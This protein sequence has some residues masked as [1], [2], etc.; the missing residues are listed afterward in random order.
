MDVNTT[1]NVALRAAW[2]C[3]G[4]P[5]LAALYL[6]KRLEQLDIVAVIPAAVQEESEI[7]NPQKVADRALRMCLVQALKLDLC[8]HEAVPVSQGP[9]LAAWALCKASSQLASGLFVAG[10]ARSKLLLRVLEGQ[11]CL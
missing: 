2:H 6:F 3:R 4:G 11:V 5:G 7:V 1:I 9:S 10:A 8:G